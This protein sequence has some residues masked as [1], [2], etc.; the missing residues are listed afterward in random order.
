MLQFVPYIGYN[1]PANVLPRDLFDKLITQLMTEIVSNQQAEWQQQM[2]IKMV[3][4]ISIFFQIQQL[5][6]FTI[7]LLRKNLFFWKLLEIYVIYVIFI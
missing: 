5:K 1:V 7:M 6:I 4:N 2:V 3:I